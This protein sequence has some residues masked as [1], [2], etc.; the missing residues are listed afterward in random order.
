MIDFLNGSEKAKKKA[1][2]DSILLVLRLIW[3][4]LPNDIEILYVNSNPYY[5]G[6]PGEIEIVNIEKHDIRKT[7]TDLRTKR[8][9]EH[10]I[11]ISATR[12][13]PKNIYPEREYVVVLIDK[14]KIEFQYLVETREADVSDQ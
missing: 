3:P 13:K 10:H 14:I 8:P 11:L 12:W 9:I 6:L 1:E 5:F 7:Y 2:R 4:D